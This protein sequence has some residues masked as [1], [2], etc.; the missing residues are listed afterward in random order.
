MGAVMRVICGAFLLVTTAC[1]EPE[2][3]PAR[4]PSANGTL[5]SGARVIVGDGTAIEN[6]AFL[7][8]D[9]KIMEVG[10][11]GAI[12]APAGV[13]TVNLAGRTVMPAMVNAHSH[14][15]WDP[16]AGG[17]ATPGTP[18]LHRAAR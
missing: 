15:G 9:H 7:V 12:Q 6:A 13:A 3:Q 14:L 1:A 8:Q 2:I 17:R 5:F 11:A 4:Q 16:A 18:D 10:K